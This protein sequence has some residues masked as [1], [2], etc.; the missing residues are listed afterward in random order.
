LGKSVPDIYFWR[1]FA[2]E[3]ARRSIATVTPLLVHYFYLEGKTGLCSGDATGPHFPKTPSRGA[4]ACCGIFFPLS[5]GKPFGKGEKQGL[6]LTP[7][8]AKEL[9]GIRE[10][11][12]STL[13]RRQ[14]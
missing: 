11:Q 8:S 1:S 9:T 6:T 10:N 14:Q 4:S 3:K 12:Q 7:G 2:A 13:P 5:D